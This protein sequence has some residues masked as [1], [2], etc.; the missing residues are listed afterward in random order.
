MAKNYGFLICILV[1]VMDIVA[2]ILG[3]QAEIT[4]NKEKP[5]KMW[6]FDCRYPSHQAFQLGLAAL[7]LLSLAHII[8]NLLGGCVCVWS[9]D[10][11]R[12]ATA[13]K[14]L[15][16]AFLIFSWLVMAV[17]FSMLIIGTL[18]NSRSRKSCG[19]FNHRFLFIGGILCFIHGLFTVPYYVSATATRREEKRQLESLGPAVRRT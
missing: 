7:I 12:S 1:M 16:M 8:A 3:I 14:Q 6:I 9:K 11:Y 2:G 10:Q 15:S 17:A 18:A 5:M 19:I 13:N 4:Q